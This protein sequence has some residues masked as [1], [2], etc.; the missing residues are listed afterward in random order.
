MNAI[1]LE[2]LECPEPRTLLAPETE[3]LVQTA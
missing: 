1:V 3:T 2:G